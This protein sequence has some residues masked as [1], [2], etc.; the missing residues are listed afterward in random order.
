MKKDYYFYATEDCASECPGIIEK[1]SSIG[2][3]DCAVFVIGNNPDT[4][5]LKREVNYVTDKNYH[6]FCFMYGN[7]EFDQGLELQLGLAKEY[8]NSPESLDKLIS[9]VKNY[10]EEKPF[11]K[12]LLL[13]I[14]VIVAIAIAVFIFVKPSSEPAEE[15]SPDEAIISEEDLP[16]ELDDVYLKAFTAAGLDANGDGAISEREIESATT[17]NLSGLG[18]SNL[19]PLLYAVNLTRLDLS[20]NEISDITDLAALA[21]LEEI[22]LTGNPIEDYTVLDYLPNLKEIQK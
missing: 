13:I 6:I 21:N 9:D 17:L 12:K 18:I 15:A 22:N 1:L 10:K 8:D 7:P 11:N 5:K 19:E 2:T 16:M 4:V 14:P 3:P 20:D